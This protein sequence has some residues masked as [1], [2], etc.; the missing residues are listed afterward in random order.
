MS[1]GTVADVVDAKVL[2]G[3]LAQV[4]GGDF[5]ARMP[6]DWTG[7]AGKVA[8]GLN[9]VIIANQALGHRTGP[10]RPGGG[11]GRAAVAAGQCSEYFSRA[12][13]AASSRSTA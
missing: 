1:D 3:V 9:D 8:D 6:M 4:K 5:T 11:Q 2:L 13:R 12:G 10:G 7:L